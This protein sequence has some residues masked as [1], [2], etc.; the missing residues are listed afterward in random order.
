L[1]L[2][3]R[4]HARASFT[5]SILSAPPCLCKYSIQYHGIRT[6]ALLEKKMLNA[7]AKGKFNKCKDKNF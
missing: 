7:S 4:K 3:G 5:V 6:E 1:E 2:K